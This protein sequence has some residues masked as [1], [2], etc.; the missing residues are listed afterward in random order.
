M[1]LVPVKYQRHIFV[2]VN[3]RE[4]GN[5]CAKRNSDAILKTLRDHVN[6]HNLFHKYNISKS[7]CLGHCDFGPTI[8]VYPDG[9]IFR[10]VTLDDTKKPIEEFLKP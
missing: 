1:E 9:Y 2:C 6:K 4:D 7:K 3:E 8:A 5:C 10:R